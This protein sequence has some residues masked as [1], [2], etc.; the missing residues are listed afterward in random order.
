MTLEQFEASVT[1]L[2]ASVPAMTLATSAGAYPWASDVYFAADGYQ[3]IF[4]S[5]PASRHSLNLAA[6]PQCASTVHPSTSSWQ[7]IKG[8]QME[9][10]AEPIEGL[11]PTAQAI[12]VYSAKFAFARHLLENPFELGKKALN[13]KAHVFRPARIHYL[14]NSLGFGTRYSVRVENGKLAGSL[15]RDAGH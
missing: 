8:L 9:G 5:S 3:L 11:E 2:F 12:L 7:E 1:A 14:D 13:V 6:N 4:F 10:T 15:Q